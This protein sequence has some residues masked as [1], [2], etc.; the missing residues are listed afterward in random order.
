MT[1]AK[2]DIFQSPMDISSME[3]KLNGGQYYT[4]EQFVGDMKTMFRNC[5]KYNGEN[6]GKNFR[7]GSVCLVYF[8]KQPK[9]LSAS[10]VCCIG[11]TRRRETHIINSYLKINNSYL[12]IK[13]IYVKFN[14]SVSIILI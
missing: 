1:E 12:K 3:K 11:T 13:Y 4:K 7:N 10:R 2:L 9:P 14:W 8:L 5:L 6:S